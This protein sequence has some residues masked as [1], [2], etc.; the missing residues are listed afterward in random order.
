MSFDAAR[1]R[2]QRHGPHGLFVLTQSSRLSGCAPSLIAVTYRSP[3]PPPIVT[4]P[5]VG[6][7]EVA[8]GAQDSTF[9]DA[10]RNTSLLKA[11]SFEC[12]PGGGGVRPHNRTRSGLA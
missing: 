5:R 9:G 3:F 12:E 2:R 1:Q 4:R 10:L 8:A 6:D 7:F 11:R